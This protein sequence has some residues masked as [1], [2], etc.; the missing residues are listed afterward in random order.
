MRILFVWKEKKIMTLFNNFFSSM[1]EFKNILIYVRR[2]TKI[3]VMGTQRDN[4][5]RSKC[6]LYLKQFVVKQARS[7]YQQQ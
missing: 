1:S 4:D 5:D 2:W 7:E 6:K 3:S